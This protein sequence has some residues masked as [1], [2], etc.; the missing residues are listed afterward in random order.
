M[1]S[2]P[3]RRPAPSPQWI[4]ATIGFVLG[5]IVAAIFVAVGAG[6]EDGQHILGRIAVAVVLVSAVMLFVLRRSPGWFR[7]TWVV[8]FSLF[9]LGT[10]A[11]GV[12]IQRRMAAEQALNSAVQSMPRELQQ[13]MDAIR[14][15]RP[16]PQHAPLVRP[17]K[18]VD[19]AMAIYLAKSTVRARIENQQRYMEELKT[20]D[21]DRLLEPSEYRRPDARARARARIDGA[22]KAL[23]GRVS[24]E[25]ATTRAFMEGMRKADLPAG[26]RNGFE[27][28]SNEVDARRNIDEMA[29][30]ERTVIHAASRVSDVLLTH[31]WQPEGSDLMFETDAGLNAFREAQTALNDAIRASETRDT[32]SQRKLQD[33]R[34]TMERMTP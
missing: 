9:L 11:L 5:I 32:Q 8:V 33:L 23:E 26:F 21:W 24:R 3:S 19:Y 22:L 12:T 2:L 10:G 31:R 20:V 14:Q 15:G 13:A 29:A 17:E 7:L 30:S 28:R 25:H 18:D 16:L 1:S 27:Q 34:D 6:G 4:A